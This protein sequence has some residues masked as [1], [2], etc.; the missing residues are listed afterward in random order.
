M[1]IG[2]V[3][4]DTEGLVMQLIDRIGRCRALL[5]DES[6]LLQSLINRERKRGARR[7]HRWSTKDDA[8]L[9]RA[10]RERGG[11]RKAAGEIGVAVEVAR[12]R[13]RHLRRRQA[14]RSEL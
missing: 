4:P 7:Y 11:V 10:A 3:P 12:H 14:A 6:L 8:I 13:L 1:K 5:A 9:L 2:D